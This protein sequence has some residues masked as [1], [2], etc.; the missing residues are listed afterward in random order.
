MKAAEDSRSRQFLVSEDIGWMGGY[1]APVWQ[2]GDL[3]DDTDDGKPFG[4]ATGT[5]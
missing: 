3:F 5:G 2:N 4:I 1:V